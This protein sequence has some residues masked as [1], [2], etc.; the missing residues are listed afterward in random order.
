MSTSNIPPD[1]S[2]E[3]QQDQALT[4][5]EIGLRAASIGWFDMSYLLV[6]IAKIVVSFGRSRPEFPRPPVL[7]DWQREQDRRSALWVLGIIISL[8]LLGWLLLK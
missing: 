5:H 7:G 1:N 2:I 3:L 6:R 8:A 4:N